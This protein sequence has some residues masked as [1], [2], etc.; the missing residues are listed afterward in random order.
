MSKIKIIITI[1]VLA[2]LVVCIFIIGAI[3]TS[4][5]NAP[6]RESID[7][8]VAKK[9][10]VGIKSYILESN[11]VE[12]KN[13]NVISGK[14]KSADLISLMREN[15]VNKQ[16][17]SVTYPAVFINNNQYETTSSKYV[18][19]KIDIYAKDR[20]VAVTPSSKESECVVTIYKVD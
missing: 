3:K 4:T 17:P 13:I 18:G 15:I 19:F 5:S 14:T 10:E 20:N 1:C 12:L 6:S 16:K 7:K 11:D 2:I 9:I 8:Q